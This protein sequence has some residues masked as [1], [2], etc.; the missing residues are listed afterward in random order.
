MTDADAVEVIRQ[1]GVYDAID[2]AKMGRRISAHIDRSA[3]EL[4]R[5]LVHQLCGRSFRRMERP[6]QCFMLEGVWIEP[7]GD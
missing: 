6:W 2:S 4:I 1:S 5:P 3:W 7:A